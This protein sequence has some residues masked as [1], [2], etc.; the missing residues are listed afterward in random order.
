MDID[1]EPSWK[2]ALEGELEKPYFEALSKAV[3]EAYQTAVIYPAQQNIFA[4]FTLCPFDQ[5]KVVILGQ[6]PYHG[7]GQAH[8]LCFSVPAGIKIP[9]SLQNIYKEI[10]ADLGTEIP[11]SGNLEHWATQGVLLLNTTLTVVENQPGSHQGLGWETFTDTVI[12][13]ISSQKEHVVFLLW[14]NFA[15]TKAALINQSKHL[16]LEAPHPSPLSAHRGFLGCRH[17]SQTNEY[18]RSAR[19]HKIIW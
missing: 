9:P 1:I 16:I 18:L 3:D 12:K 13:T 6:D 11:Q 10:K 19:V 5:I 14:G 7:P 15:R 4:A 2:A 17:F 8:G